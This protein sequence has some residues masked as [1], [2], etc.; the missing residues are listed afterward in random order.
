MADRKIVVATHGHC[1]DGLVSAALFTHLRR[2]IQPAVARFRYLSLGYGPAMP[3]VPENWLRG[4]EN[5]IIDFRFS[6][7]DRLTWYF[8]HHPTGFASD[9]ERATALASSKRVFFDPSYAS[10][11]KLIADVGRKTFSVDFQAYAELIG[12]ADRIDSASFA[13]VDDA[14]DRTEPVMQ[15]A[16]VV[17]QHGQGALLDKLI[18]QL[19]RE[20]V[21]E[22]AR[23]SEVQ[24][25]WLPLAETHRLARERVAERAER[26]GAVVYVDLHDA[27]L[28]SSGKFYHYAVQP[29]AQYSVSLIRMKQ[30][31]KLS[32][33]HNPW[34]SEP[35]RHDIA[36]ICRRFGGGGHAD[37]GAVSFALDKLDEALRVAKVVVAKLNSEPA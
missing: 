27:P 33:G 15:L 29:D 11:S 5:A 34:A 2:S 13:T 16:N 19:L 30:H 8:D 35:R 6:P 3:T 9:E 25:L 7:S 37:V 21:G 36:E 10:C 24:A 31:F 17:E 4:D 20:P 22:V 12:W 18:E 23:S 28:G 32:V 26:Q 14:L 1:F